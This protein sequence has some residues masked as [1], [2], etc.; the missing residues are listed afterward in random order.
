M[1]NERDILCKVGILALT[2]CVWSYRLKHRRAYGGIWR[3][4][5]AYGGIGGHME[6]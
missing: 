4:S 6:A 1:K 5:E 2:V 3:Y